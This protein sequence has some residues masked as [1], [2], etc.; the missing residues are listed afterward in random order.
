VAGVQSVAGLLLG[1]VLELDLLEE[2]IGASAREGVR[3]ELGCDHRIDMAVLGV[4]AT[5]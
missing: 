1:V 5:E 4:E 3:R 2:Q